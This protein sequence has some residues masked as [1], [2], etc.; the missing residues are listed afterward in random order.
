MG[1]GKILGMAALGV[2]AVAAA[3]FTGGG[4]IL[5]AT[6]AAASLAGA[7]TV[8]TAVGVGAAGAVAGAAMSDNEEEEKRESRR[9]REEAE[10]NRR[11]AEE[12]EEE[13]EKS[14]KKAEKAEKKAEKNRKKAEEAQAKF[15]E[16][17]AEER[18][19]EEAKRKKEAK[20]KEKKAE[21]V[22]YIQAVTALAVSMAHIDGDYAE[23][24]ETEID[25]YLETL[26]DSGEY[27]STV[28]ESLSTIVDNPPSLT[29]ALSYLDKVQPNK[30]GEIRQLLEDVMKADGNIAKKEEYFM[31][32]FDKYIK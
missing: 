6:G 2:G 16:Q 9:A 21:R 19:E 7:G 14:R 31:T 5:A 4:S 8:A 30:Y 17:K 23:E 3:P 10:E 13:A 24:E 18:K 32:R 28:L 22:N 15:E 29:E 12:A 26:A 20:K 27:E 25:E 1:W 11:R